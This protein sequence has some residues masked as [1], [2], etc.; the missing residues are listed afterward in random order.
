[1]NILLFAALAF[2]Y[3]E[4]IQAR[5]EKIIAE[6]CLILAEGEDASL[7]FLDEEE[8]TRIMKDAKLIYQEMVDVSNNHK[9]M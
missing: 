5:D 4:Q 3:F 8:K 6:K 7:I 9:H 1:M 2:F